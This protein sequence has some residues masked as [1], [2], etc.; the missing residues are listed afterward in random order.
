LK[1]LHII[2]IQ[3]SDLY[4]H[5]QVKLQLFNL[6]KFDHSKYYRGL[7]FIPYDRIHQ[8]IPAIWKELELE[9][10]E[11]HFSY[12]FDY[13]QVLMD[14]RRTQY[15]SLLR[16]YCFAKHLEEN[17]D[18]TKDSIFYIDSDVLFIKSPDFIDEYLDKDVCYLSD[19]KSYLNSDYFDSKRAQVLPHK[20]EDYDKRDVLEEIAN[21][22]GTTR[23]VCEENKNNTGGA[24]TL[25]PKNSIDA[26]FWNDIYDRAIKIRTHLYYGFPNSVNGDFFPS[27]D[28]GFQSWAL[29]DMAGLLFSLWGRSIKTETPQSMDF[30]WATDHISKWDTHNIFHLAGAGPQPMKVNGVDHQIFFKG[31]YAN[32]N[33]TPF[34]EKEESYLLATSP[35]YCSYNYVQ[36]ILQVRDKYYK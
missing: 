1:N 19:T 13:G 5:W 18:L 25:F 30:C 3:P 7:I 11:A 36:E 28:A 10:P 31:F 29:G 6:R 8:G 20:L 34:D 17:P 15:V 27:E 4:F 33:K 26:K 23:K 16:P 22:C 21:I 14:I 9:F 12:Y 35:D 2:T 32:N 24:Q